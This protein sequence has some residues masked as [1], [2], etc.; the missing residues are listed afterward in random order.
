MARKTN[1]P[2][3]TTTAPAEPAPSPCAACK[4]TGTVAV[5]VRVGRRHH[6][7]GSQDGMC[8]GCFGTGEA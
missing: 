7:V 6:V 5:T 4:G 8:L 2:A 3:T 1:R